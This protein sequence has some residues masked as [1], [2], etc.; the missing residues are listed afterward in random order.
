MNVLL[1]SSTVLPR[2]ASR[3]HVPK[4]LT[5][6]HQIILPPFDGPSFYLPE[7]V[8]PENSIHEEQINNYLKGRFYYSYAH[9]FNER[10]M[11]EFFSWTVIR[12][13]VSYIS[14]SVPNIFT[15]T[16]RKF[17]TLVNFN[18]SGLS[19]NPADPAFIVFQ[20]NLSVTETID[21]AFMLYTEPSLPKKPAYEGFNYVASHDKISLFVK[22]Q[23]I[24]Q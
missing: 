22:A 17:A 20:E 7:H 1:T 5:L 12:H 3:I 14:Y 15:V 9:K 4:F 8:Q 2:S 11:K 16:A 21:Y 18:S 6:G 13:N 23:I 19:N 10:E 24:E